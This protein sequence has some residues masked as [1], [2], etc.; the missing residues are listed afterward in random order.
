VIVSSNHDET[1]LPLVWLFNFPPKCNFNIIIYTW[2][3]C[4]KWGSPHLSRLISSIVINFLGLWYIH[5][6]HS[7]LVSQFQSSSIKMMIHPCVGISF[8]GLHFHNLYKDWT[9]PKK[10]KLSLKLFKL[11]SKCSFKKT[12]KASLKVS[13]QA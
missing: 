6:T 1:P 2:N 9:H 10:I 13:S 4:N 11:L 3:S 8:N 12:L 5:K 7:N